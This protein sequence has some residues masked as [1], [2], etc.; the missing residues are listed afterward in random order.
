MLFRSEKAKYVADSLIPLFNQENG[1]FKTYANF[2]ENNS[3]IPQGNEEA[4]L[5]DLGS[6]QLEFFT[7]SKLTNN[8]KYAEIGTKIYSFLFKQYLNSNLFPERISTITGKS[9]SNVKSMDSMSDS[10]YEY[11]I[12]VWVMTNNTQ[13]IILDRYLRS[14]K[15]LKNELLVNNS[16]WTYITKLSNDRKDFSMTHL[17]TFVPGMLTVGSVKQNPNYLEDLILADQLV[18]TYVKLYNSQSLGFMPECIKFN[19]DNFHSCDSGYYLRPETIESI[20]VL[21]RFT[22]LQKY[23]D[24]AYKIFKNL[25]KNCKINSGGFATIDDTNNNSP[26]HRDLMDSYFLAETL[27]YLYLIFSDSNILPSDEWVFNT[28]AHPMKIWSKEEALKIFKFIKI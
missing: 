2:D 24:Y 3:P 7:L 28:E 12:K 19:G 1:L 4:L 9:F 25:L 17:V 27:K 6:I 21:Y 23:R 14:I 10:F 18:T 26:N 20:Y 8:K 13:P 16:K 11:L 5:S 15:S 22:G